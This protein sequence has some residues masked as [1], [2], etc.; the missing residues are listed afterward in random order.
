MGR[1][2][3]GSSS[4]RVRAVRA[5]PRVANRALE[6]TRL[7]IASILGSDRANSSTAFS[8][9]TTADSTQAK[10][11]VGARRPL[12]YS[13]LAYSTAEGSNNYMNMEV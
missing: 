10:S 1:G 6:A 8:R 12:N 3:F 7:R 11:V 13:R 2:G 4:D 9:R 5:K